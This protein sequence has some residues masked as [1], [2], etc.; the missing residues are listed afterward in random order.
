MNPWREHN[1]ELMEKILANVPKFRVDAFFYQPR[2]PLINPTFKERFRDWF[3]KRIL[4]AAVVHAF[5]TGKH[6]DF[7]RRLVW[8]EIPTISFD[9]SMSV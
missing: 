4:E 2:Y 8:R 5:I 3:L 1:S 7:K 6:E 9:P